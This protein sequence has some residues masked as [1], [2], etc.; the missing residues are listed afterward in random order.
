MATDHALIT[1][2]PPDLKLF[3]KETEANLAVNPQDQLC[4]S[5]RKCSA[6]RL[7]EVGSISAGGDDEVGL[8]GAIRPETQK[9][10]RCCER[11]HTGQLTVKYVKVSNP[12]LESQVTLFGYPC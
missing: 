2:Y 6:S 5:I 7:C 11:L 8:V 3:S 1:D 12:C 10:R 9:T 4:I